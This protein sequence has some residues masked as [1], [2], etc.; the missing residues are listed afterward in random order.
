MSR[1]GSTDGSSCRTDGSVEPTPAPVPD[2]SEL[3]EPNPVGTADSSLCSAEGG[4][5][6]T[7][8]CYFL[9]VIAEILLIVGSFLGKILVFF[10][11]IL[12]A[13]AS[14]NDFGSTIVVQ[15]GW[16]IVRDIVNM[17]FIIVLLLSA[18]SSIIGYEDSFH[19]K[20]VLPK[21]L[22]MAVLINFSRTLI[23]LLIDFSQ[24]MMLTFVNA[25][26]QAG[27][28]NL[29]SALKLDA[30][31]RMAPPT[32]GGTVESVN[33]GEVTGTI[34]QINIILALMLAI[35]MLSIALGVII[36][37]TAYLI[38]R[39]VGLWIALILSPIALFAT[40]LPGK[41]QKAV[42]PFTGKYWA[43]L[44][45]LLTGGPVMAFF[46][47]LTFA[48]TQSSSGEGGLAPA[49]NIELTNPTLNLFLTSV[50]TSQDVASFIVGVTLMLMGLDAAVSAAGAISETLGKYA[51]T[52]SNYAQSG[53]RLLAA[54]PFLLGYAGA[55]YAD[56]R[57]DISG[58]AATAGAAVTAL[59]LMR[60]LTPNVIQKGLK[61]GM[62]R[63]A[64]LDAEE[65]KE[66][67][68]GNE[69]LSTKQRAIVNAQQRG[70]IPTRGQNQAFADQMLERAGK[71]NATAIKD[72]LMPSYI[73][74]VTAERKNELA[75]QGL[76]GKA[77][78]DKLVGDKDMIKNRA[79]QKADRDV[80]QR[81]AYF[82]AQARQTAEKIG[83]EDMMRSIDDQIKENPNLAL[84]KTKI[85]KK[86]LADKK[87]L[88]GMSASA[89]S[90]GATL[91]AIM[92]QA[93]VFSKDKDGAITGIDRAKM[94]QFQDKITDKDLRENVESLEKLVR[95][96]T[97]ELMVDPA[98][99]SK[100][101]RTGTMNAAQLQ[102][103]HM[104]KDENG[105]ARMFNMPMR[106]AGKMQQLGSEIEQLT[107]LP[108]AITGV[109][110]GPEAML[111]MPGATG[112]SPI[113][114]ERAKQAQ[115]RLDSVNAQIQSALANAT[116]ET[117]VTNFDDQFLRSELD[118]LDGELRT[119]VLGVL[120]NKGLDDAIKG[121]LERN[122]EN[123]NFNIV[124]DA[125][126]AE[127]ASGKM[128]L[129]NS[130]AGD[131]KKLGN[132]QQ[133]K[134]ASAMTPV[135][136]SYEA[137]RKAGTAGKKEDK[138]I[139]EI[140]RV[141]ASIEEDFKKSGRSAP[142]AAEEAVIKANQ[143][144]RK[145]LNSTVEAER[146]RFPGKLKFIIEEETK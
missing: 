112:T 33:G 114:S 141:N 67:A 127:A 145:A 130:V 142:N 15:R 140:V 89:K 94:E 52:V 106:A 86:L 98:D 123:L 83:D 43:R 37:M 124:T 93:G 12:I 120:E 59:P 113:Q 65:R 27:P 125:I 132:D 26:A 139:E 49:L 77:L 11:D 18:F 133:L 109:A 92:D 60:S 25:F 39:I 108:G 131:I 7:V 107:A 46:L 111:G 41:L 91:H 66:A 38:F 57:L 119:A 80:Q 129:V 34:D 146:K 64:R 85:A 136:T 32:G 100:G 82:L 47:W 115:A 137:M 56:R 2:A 53:G 69:F 110:A 73:N 105:K 5:L 122:G 31:F 118:R 79:S 134:I 116:N 126:T 1:Y 6:S 76:S 81:Q 71:K 88:N 121:G 95:G 144:I 55:R 9:Y 29:V 10:T 17:F 84:D 16:V 30:V 19:Y 62:T 103:L 51:K 21:L 102:N 117:G 4:P 40:A 78:D 68:K 3:A 8:R 128:D 70:L 44:S 72:E 87:A 13:F 90:D 75:A 74:Q 135:I 28:G 36:I 35:F 23:Q 22:L 61:A 54:S 58:K 42:D 96:N 104:G 45:A 24:V 20:R 138:A 50:G 101:T 99:P 143:E 63:N 97:G 14:Y 48:I